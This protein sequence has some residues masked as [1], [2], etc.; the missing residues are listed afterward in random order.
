MAS[1]FCGARQRDP[2]QLAR[3]CVVRRVRRVGAVH[4]RP[5]YPRAQVAKLLNAEECI[6]IARKERGM[7]LV[8]IAHSEKFWKAIHQRDS[9][10]V[11]DVIHAVHKAP[12]HLE[13]GGNGNTEIERRSE[14]RSREKHGEAAEQ[15]SGSEGTPEGPEERQRRDCTANSSRVIDCDRRSGNPRA[16]NLRTD[17]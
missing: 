16:A 2:R 14:E 5:L 12:T 17:E 13:G 11:W 1:P 15:E 6:A 3:A 10:T 7:V 9:R 8:E 4:H